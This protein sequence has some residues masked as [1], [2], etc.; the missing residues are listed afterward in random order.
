MIGLL[1]GI[2]LGG[3]GLWFIQQ[4]RAETWPQTKEQAVADLKQLMDAKREALE[5][6]ADKI[7]K[8]LAETGRVVRRRASAFGDQVAD[9]V[10]DA[11]ITAAIKA[12]LAA[13]RELSALAISVSTSDGIV[14]L[15]G[16]VASPEL[17]GQA[18]LLALE[19]EG[20][21]EVIATLQVA[22]Q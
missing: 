17:V 13:D 5:L 20:V 16:K 10:A 22:K 15:S 7:Q 1:L 14:S 3:G 6:Q 12:K 8:E 18:M 19:T 9:A 2:M 21:R 11:R 4:R